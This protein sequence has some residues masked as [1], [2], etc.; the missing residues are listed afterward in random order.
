[1]ENSDELRQRAERYRRMALSITDAQATEALKELAAEYDALATALE[2]QTARL[3]WRIRLAGANPI[4]LVRW[5]RRRRTVGVRAIPALLNALRDRGTQRGH[6]GSK[7]GFGGL[8][9]SLGRPHSAPNFSA[10]PAKATG[11]WCALHP[12][13]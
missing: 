3:G 8:Q 11:G 13:R 5:C 9:E 6:L 4:R 7:F 2:A 10:V 12:F 1:M